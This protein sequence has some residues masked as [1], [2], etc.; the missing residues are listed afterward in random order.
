MTRTT[1]RILEHKEI[2][3]EIK[4]DFCDKVFKTKDDE[5]PKGGFVDFHFGYGSVNDDIF[6]D[7]HGLD[8]C[9]ECF[10]KKFEKFYKKIL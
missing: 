3:D 10:E 1:K 8:I 2:I 5:F 9:D 7:L 6:G 4:C